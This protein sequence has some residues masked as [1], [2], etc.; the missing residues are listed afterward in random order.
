[1]NQFLKSHTSRSSN[2]ARS[3]AIVI[4]LA[5]TLGVASSA[6]AIFYRFG[7]EVHADCTSD[8]VESLKFNSVFNLDPSTNVVD[9]VI[10][11]PELTGTVESVAIYDINDPNVDEVSCSVTGATTIEDLGVSLSGSFTLTG[12]EAI[13]LQNGDY[14]IRVCVRIGPISFYWWVRIIKGFGTIPIYSVHLTGTSLAKLIS[15]PCP[16]GVRFWCKLGFSCA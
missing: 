15:N 14:L 11:I 16:T 6:Y 1:M 12:G 4:A 7:G 9:Y 8:E 2:C 5:V 13:A 3:I 10:K